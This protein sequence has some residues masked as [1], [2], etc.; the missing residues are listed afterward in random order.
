MSALR[1]RR[2]RPRVLNVVG[3][4]AGVAL[5]GLVAAALVFLASGGRWFIVATPSM[6]TIAPVGTL[7][8]T[9]PTPV[10]ALHA[11][12]I[13]SFHPPTATA[14]TYT[15]RVLNVSPQGDVTT[16]GDIN[17]AVDPWTLHEADL[18]GKAGTVL[19]GVGWLARALPIIAVGLVLVFLLTRLVRSRQRR[20]ALRIVGVT[21][22][23][24]VAAY[25]LRPF[26]GVEVLQTYVAGGKAGATVVSTGLLPIRVTAEHGNHVDLLTGQ[27]GQLSIPGY[28]TDGYYRLSS[29]LHLDAA[30]WIA[31]LLVCCIPLIGTMIFGLPPREAA[32]DE[33]HA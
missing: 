15:H 17:G 1:P 5:I 29:A 22:V 31:F 27:V 9:T 21:L 24:S 6:G 7:V 30:G 32:D 20:A 8:L 3:G 33:Q 4:V 2:S 11:G 25:I 26:T 23:V 19:P 16:K 13:I 12:D 18:I 28:L 10:S 14:E